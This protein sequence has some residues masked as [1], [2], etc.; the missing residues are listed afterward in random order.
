MLD[1]NLDDDLAP[2]VKVLNEW[3]YEPK[4]RTI[5]SRTPEQISQLLM[6]I[7]PAAQSILLSNGDVWRYDQGEIF[8]NP[9]V[10]DCTVFLQTLGYTNKKHSDTKY[11]ICF[12][13]F[14]WSRNLTA[15]VKQIDKN[16]QWGFSCLN[17]SMSMERVLL[18]SKL[19]Q[20]GLLDSIIYSQN[21]RFKENL[22][23]LDS[24]SEFVDLLPISYYEDTSD[25]ARIAHDHTTN[26]PAF[27]DAY[28]NIA[29]ESA[30]EEY[31][32]TGKTNLEISTEKS[33]KPFI[34]KQIPL[35]LA[36]RGHY[37]YL[38]SLGFEM[39]SDFLPYGYDDMCYTD[40]V[41]CVVETVAKGREYAQDF[42]FSHLQEIEHNYSLVNSDAVETRI[43]QKIKDVL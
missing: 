4:L 8:K 38:E 41:H 27:T 12:P 17:N 21:I 35:I 42:Y 25:H 7:N 10:E 30:C 5:S 9:A 15:N 36:G 32:F 43:L 40:K 29:V 24:Y 23:H 19:Q 37:A 2:L 28:C 6:E 26:H 11:T 34:S 16:A 18:G 22:P 39:M 3:G 14:Y 1:F 33:Y 31:P 20:A 13:K